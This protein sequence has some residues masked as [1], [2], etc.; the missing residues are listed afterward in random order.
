MNIVLDL[1]PQIEKA[2]LCLTTGL[3]LEVSHTERLCLGEGQHAISILF[4]CGCCD[5]RLSNFHDENPHE[6]A[7]EALACDC[8]VLATLHINFDCKL[9]GIFELDGSPIDELPME[10]FIIARDDR[11][12]LRDSREQGMELLHLNPHQVQRSNSPDERLISEEE[13]ASLLSLIIHG[14]PECDCHKGKGSEL[15]LA[16]AGIVD[17]A[18]IKQNRLAEKCGC[19]CICC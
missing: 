16:K 13:K 7:E 17:M 18:A 8:N 15:L 9:I 2:V 10:T 6:Y 12:K 1:I 19:N 4:K 11:Q 14:C 5:A 3:P